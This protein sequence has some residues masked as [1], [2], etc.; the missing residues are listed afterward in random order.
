[1]H[2]CTQNAVQRTHA[3]AAAIEYMSC[4]WTLCLLT[5]T[6]PPEV[7]DLYILGQIE[8]SSLLGSAGICARGGHTNELWK[9]QLGLERRGA[10]TH[11][12]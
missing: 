6:S 8:N 1:M 9:Q 5:L 12:R 7:H 4:I 11:R 2:P 10:D 3:T